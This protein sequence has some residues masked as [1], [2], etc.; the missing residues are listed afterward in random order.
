MHILSTTN[1]C[2]PSSLQKSEQEHKDYIEMTKG[3]QQLDP[4][5][6]I[7]DQQSLTT[8]DE[9]DTVKP[10]ENGYLPRYTTNNVMNGHVF[11]N[12]E[13]NEH[14]SRYYNERFGQEYLKNVTRQPATGT[15]SQA[16]ARR[17]N[18]YLTNARETHGRGDPK[19]DLLNQMINSKEVFRNKRPSLDNYS[20]NV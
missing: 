3:L 9:V 6:D 4:A 20:Y 10:R 2:K 18:N 16:F 7:I 8:D 19:I 14:S 1:I 15:F 13:T 17:Y 11:H 12:P 5:L